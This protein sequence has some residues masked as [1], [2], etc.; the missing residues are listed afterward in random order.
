MG[1]FNEY[2]SKFKFLKDAGFTEVV[3]SGTATHVAGNHLDQMWTNLEI[4][5][6]QIIKVDEVCSDHLMI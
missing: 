2:L 1:D 4:A 5:S 6:S 3:P